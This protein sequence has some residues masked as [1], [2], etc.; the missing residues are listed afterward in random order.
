MVPLFSSIG[1]LVPSSSSYQTTAMSKSL[2]VFINHPLFCPLA[3]PD[4]SQGIDKQMV[5]VRKIFIEIVNMSHI[6]H[7]SG[8][9]NKWLAISHLG[10]TSIKTSF[11]KLAAKSVFLLLLPENNR[12][13][14]LRFLLYLWCIRMREI[15]LFEWSFCEHSAIYICHDVCN[16]RIFGPKMSWIVY[17]FSTTNLCRINILSVHSWV[18]SHNWKN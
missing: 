16:F 15:L 10:G 11:D 17:I 8:Q 6:Y 5:F 1:K 9:T 3:P 4:N 14:A 2:K 18:I 13:R 12:W 7:S